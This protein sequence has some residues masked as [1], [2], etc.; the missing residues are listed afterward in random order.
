MVS[1]SIM[2]LVAAVILIRQDSFNGAVLLQSQAY[3]VALATREVQLNAVSASVIQGGTRQ[4]LGLYFSTN[5]SR[6]MRYRIF[7]DTQNNGSYDPS[8]EYG[9]QPA[10][11]SPFEIKAIRVDGSNR[12]DVTVMFERPNFDAKFYNGAVQLAG[13]EVEVEIGPKGSSSSDR[14]TIVITATGQITVR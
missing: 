12:E 10:L 9:Q 1:I 14:K 11:D 13:S 2:M 4:M 5:A 7:R 3:E 6:N 8:E